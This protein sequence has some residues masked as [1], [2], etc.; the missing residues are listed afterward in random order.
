MV[1]VQLR[2][3]VENENSQRGMHLN[4]HRESTLI[5]RGM[6]FNDNIVGTRVQ[7]SQLHTVFN[8]FLD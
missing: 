5:Q 4:D 2:N 1:S 6:S 8:Y 7:S 3:H